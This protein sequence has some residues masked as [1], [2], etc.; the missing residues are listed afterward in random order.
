MGAP[1]PYPETWLEPPPGPALV[2]APHPDDETIG[3][4]GIIALHRARGDAVHVVVATDGDR[5]DPEGRY[6]GGADYVARRRDEC[7]RATRVLDLDEPL[8]LGLRDRA[9]DESAL[10]AR[11]GEV[12]DRLRPAVLYHP[13]AA[14]MHVDHQVVG[15]TLLHAVARSGWTVRTFAY[16][17]WGPVIPTHVIDVSSVWS[18]KQ[19]AL[20]CYESQL[21]YNDYRRATAGLNAYRAIFLPHADFVEA[22]AETTPCRARARWRLPGAGLL[23]RLGQ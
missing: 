11:L 15:E 23:R 13:G 22:F 2:V 5:G 3:C 16:E 20:A 6:P 21:V 7:R 10:L 8:F 9:I 19:E 18:V 4:G 12:V 17:V 14:E 1:L